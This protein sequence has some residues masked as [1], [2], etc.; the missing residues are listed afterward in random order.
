MGK[1]QSRLSRAAC[2]TC[3]LASMSD[4]SGAGLE[5]HPVFRHLDVAAGLPDQHVESIIQDVHGYVW[6]GTRGGLVRHEGEQLR[7]LPRN[8]A[9]PGSLPDNNVMSLHAH[10]DGM[11]W[12][13]VAGEGVVEIGP[14]LLP[15]RHLAPISADGIL[16]A[17]NVWSMAEDCKGGLWMGFMREGVARFDP[18]TGSLA[19][20]APGEVSGLSADGY[21]LQLMVDSHCRTWVAQ[22][23]RLSVYD[24]ASDEPLFREVLRRGPGARE[25]VVSVMEHETHGLFAAR[26]NELLSLG[27]MEL[28]AD[29]E[30]IRLAAEMDGLVG[31]L[32]VLPDGRI[33]VLSQSALRFFDP[34]S[35]R[36]ESID[37]QPA[38]RDSLPGGRLSGAQLIDRE[39]GIWLAV[40]RNGLVYLP[41]R[42]GAFGRLEK[43][44]GS[45]QGFDLERVSVV[46]TT[47]DPDVVWVGADE[48]EQRINLR[49]GQMDHLR[50]L[51]PEWRTRPQIRTIQGLLPWDEAMLVLEARSLVYLSPQSGRSRVLLDRE[52]LS[53]VLFGFFLPATKDKLWIGTRSHGVLRYDLAD[54]VFQV[55]GPDRE[56]PYHLPQ[57]SVTT[58]I[59]DAQNGFW[60]AAANSIYRYSDHEGFSPVAEVD[61]SI[62]DLALGPDDLLW[63]ATDTD[64]SSWSWSE[65]GLELAVRYD[66]SGLTE[67]AAIRQIFP[68]AEDRLWM[69]LSTGIAVLDLATGHT[70]TFTGSDGLAVAQFAAGASA[71]LEDGRLLVG[72]D[73]GL[74]VVDPQFLEGHPVPP[75]VH[76]TRLAAADHVRP[77]SPGRKEPVSLS[78]RQNSVRL[79]FSAPTFVAP[80]RVRY[81]V[82]LEGWD[83]DWLVLRRQSQMYYSNLRPGRYRFQVQAAAAGD[84][85]SAQGDELIIDI[86]RPP[87]AGN[88]ALSA[89]A[90]LLLAATGGGWQGLQ[91]ARRRRTELRDIR[92]KRAL[93]EQQRQLIQRLN[94]DLDPLPLA[95]T[96]VA[97]IFR[98]TDAG[99]ACFGYV[100]ELMPSALVC[101]G[102]TEQPD[103]Q[104]WLQRLDCGDDERERSVDF[105]ADRQR[106]ARVLLTAPA[107]GFPP[108]QEQRLALLVD[109][110]AQSLHNSILLQRVKHLADRAE[111]ASRAKSEFLATMSHEIR[112]P[113]HGLMGMTDLLHESGPD[114]GQQELIE[115][116][117]ASGR[118]LQ[119]V[120]DDVLDISRIEAGHLSLEREPFELVS[121]L[122]HVVDLHA[123]NAARKHLDL[124][125]RLHSRLP[126]VAEG[127]PDRL[128]QVLGNLLSNAVKFTEQG[129]VELSAAVDSHGRL[130][131]QVADSG[132]GVP[133]AARE[134]LWQPF[135]QL[136]ASIGRVHGGSG[137][138]LAICR[139][140]TTAMGGSIEFDEPCVPGSRF[141]VRLPAGSLSP[142]PKLTSLLDRTC[143]VALVDVPTYRVLLSLSRRWGFRV[144]NG[145]KMLPA[146]DA[147]VLIDSRMDCEH[148]HVRGWLEGKRSGIYLEAPYA[149]RNRSSIDAGPYDRFLRWPLLE[150]RLVGVLLDL[151]MNPL[152]ADS[153][154]R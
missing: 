21:L 103:R 129:S 38:L 31:G 111:Q 49:T 4:G 12:A 120:I 93:A 124:R 113:L 43:V 121:L 70:R 57:S 145:W 10:S 80:E 3:L 40:S 126:L 7:L 146:A 9:H 17:E 36:T 15:R 87:W 107:G 84:A 99:Q 64:L 135:T 91:Q 59:G 149:A 110:A 123:P 88:W 100:H 48:G 133:V 56:P 142:G 132:P 32:S 141:S 138:G 148:P 29:S 140:L 75:P 154:R 96:I 25:F 63:V 105:E 109:L 26:G 27:S 144:A 30:K 35:G 150:S 13:G 152:S 1:R 151:A 112:T 52:S 118:Q 45:D 86:A 90:L 79:E 23:D 69:V 60:L 62:S 65:S 54:E 50:A 139:R 116:L 47:S 20:F 122:E 85:W 14:D 106:I 67:T 77:L 19:A 130:L 143:L 8:P 11:V 42:Y 137:L 125:L 24:P 33:L 58:M 108:D 51:F 102:T 94:A 6:I 44:P 89:Y 74:V 97:E 114:G 2:L 95:R 117:R 61:G 22:T 153:A 68:T 128:A 127:D 71:R 72:G 101:S 16:P 92:N 28:D 131:L 41:P 136:D 18:A 104:D 81:R 46:A 73:R 53:A 83:E 37:P 78:W 82:R 66:V 134:R 115:T 147:L 55:F 76:L 98:M 39:G 119:R 34:D 5:S